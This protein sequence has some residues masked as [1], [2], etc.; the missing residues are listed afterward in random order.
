MDVSK[1]THALFSCLEVSI[2]YPFSVSPCLFLAFDIV[3]GSPPYV[4]Y[5]GVDTSTK[6]MKKKQ[7]SYLTSTGTVV[8]ELL[9]YN[10]AQGC[11]LFYLVEIAA[12]F[13]DREEEMGKSD[14]DQI[15]E[16]FG[17]GWYVMLDS[18]D[19]TP[20]Q[21]KRVYIS[22]IPLVRPF[23]QLDPPARLCFDDGYDLVRSIFDPEKEEAKVPCLM[24]N[25]NFLDD[26]PRMSVYKQHGSRQLKL[27]RRTPTVTERERLMGL[28]PGYVS[29]PGKSTV[30]TAPA[31]RS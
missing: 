23:D 28:P 6:A 4:H 5:S 15:L 17:I 8:N 14:L 9:R 3:I 16:A 18:K 19:H 21:R 11:K 12:I 1:R 7:A 26:H 24:T 10:K 13:H 29:Q 27:Y 30:E 31:E 22:N 20:L 2:S 25:K